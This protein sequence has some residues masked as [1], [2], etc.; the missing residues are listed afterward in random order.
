M[1]HIVILIRRFKFSYS[2]VDFF[3]KNNNNIR[4]LGFLHRPNNAFIEYL[5]QK[6]ERLCLNNRFGT[7]L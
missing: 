6:T 7:Y 1:T 2:I 5:H 3:L 4:Y